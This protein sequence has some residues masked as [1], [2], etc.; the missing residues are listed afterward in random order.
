MYLTDHIPLKCAMMRKWTPAEVL[1]LRGQIGHLD[2]CTKL[3]KV[4]VD[5]KIFNLHLDECIR[6]PEMGEEIGNYQVIN[7][8][9]IDE[10]SVF[11]HKPIIVVYTIDGRI[12]ADDLRKFWRIVE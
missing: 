11:D 10:E 8:C 7:L 2:D 12:L 3:V 9:N 1:R 5:G 4:E 6:I